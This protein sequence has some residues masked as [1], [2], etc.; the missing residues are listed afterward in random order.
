MVLHK[1]AL[2]LSSATS[3]EQI[4][5]FTLDA[6]EVAL[7]FDFA[8]ILFV[9][10]GCLRVKGNR[11]MDVTFPELPLTG[12]GLTVRAARKK[13]SIRIP[14][15]RKED[16]YVDRLGFDWTDRPTMLSE[17]A[18]PTILDREAVAVLNVESKRFDDFSEEDQKLLETLGT[19]VASAISRLRRDEA[20][21]E[22]AS[23]HRATL[24]STADG[25]LVVDRNGKVIT[26]NRKFAEMWRIPETLLETK[27]DAQLLQF[28]F[29]QL[30]EPGQFLGKVQ[31]LYSKPE[32]ESF[33]VLMFADGR[34][35]ERY[36]QPQR[37]GER[38]VGR[39]WSFRDVTIRKQMEEALR[40]RGDELAA[41]QETVLDITRVRYDSQSL[42]EAIVERATRLLGAQGGGLDL[43]D[44]VKRETRCVVSYNTP[45]DFKGLVLKYGEGSSGRVAETGKPF[46]IDDYREWEGGARIPGATDLGAVLS[47]PMIWQGQVTGVIQ[48]IEKEATRHF[49]QS[50][51]D[52]LTLFANHAA[53]AVENSHR[54]ENL[55]KLVNERT[56]ALGKSEAKYGS[57]VQNIPVMVWTS[58]R[59][60][61]TV[62]VTP[63][64]HQIFGY[65]EKEIYEG[66]YS[67]WSSR[68]HPDDI[69]RLEIGY[70]SLFTQG[71]AFDV[72]YRFQ[73][74]DGRWVW[75][76][77]SATRTYEIDGVQYADGVTSDIT[78]RKWVEEKLRGAERLAAV[79]ETAAMV[80]HDLRN[81]LQAISTAGYI[82][83]KTLAQTADERLREMLE[84]IEG[85]V[86]YS[87]KIVGDL[88]EYSEDLRLELSETTPK[89]LA[90][91]AF[92]Q[93]KIPKNITVSDLTSDDPPI[94]VDAAKIRRIFVNLIENAID[95]MPTG[96]ELTVSSKISTNELEVKF[97]DT[98]KGIPENVLR[99]IW[100]PLITTK[101]KGMGLGLAI[102]KR[103][104]E[105]HRGSISVDSTV[106]KGTTFTLRLPGILNQEG[107]KRA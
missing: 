86:A 88:L 55:E 57:V 71:I 30:K 63:N 93:M 90:R 46:I 87:N 61:N 32:E 5:R 12:R 95:A 69:R 104:A 56:L 101:P 23:L 8:D 42:L 103:V 34:V 81:P 10:G 14:D 89:S 15:T 21:Q 20:L 26:F 45:H 48:V 67:L 43:C 107:A 13:A 64:V 96:G 1:H 50:D 31:E 7:G 99:E 2:Q 4:V 105:A 39:V 62:F 51:L 100:K 52:M 37:L 9:E 102:C 77:D 70:E 3:L 49:T 33:D 60:A 98:G 80:A 53:I 47:V 91:D 17:L 78:E 38:I 83:K 6:M 92:R 59:E 75:L 11:G 16:A 44:P 97:T 40:R 73:R 36:S 66:G 22:S 106:G 79:G 28:V 94:R 84:V 82:I 76:H 24:E 29:N 41:L 58:D 85:S 68:I 35:F 65:S 72:E 19:H 18:V 27:D 54:A 25:I 74:T